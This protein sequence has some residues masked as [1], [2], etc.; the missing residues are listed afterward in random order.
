M[1]FSSTTITKVAFLFITYVVIAGGVLTKGLPCQ[2][3][4]ELE[5]N[6]YL[7]H[8]IGFLCI[9]IFI[10]MEGGW[11]FKYRNTDNMDTNNDSNSK[12]SEEDIDNN[13]SN[14]NSIQTFFYS[15]ILYLIFILSSKMQL[16]PNLLFFAIL[17]ILYI[18][19]T[20]TNYWVNRKMITPEQ[21]SLSETIQNGLI[22]SSLVVFV[23]G[24]FDY[25]MYQKRLRGNKFDF[26]KFILGAPKCDYENK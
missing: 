4:K 10:M 5:T 17:F 22:G 23:Y 2:L 13:F 20:Q 11:D 15:I 25:V 8:F 12:N 18:V 19:A 24:F 3:Q 21:L 6:R 16:F 14:A 7:Q 26:K 9:F 1:F